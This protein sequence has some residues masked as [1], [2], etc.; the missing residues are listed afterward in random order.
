VDRA[1]SLTEVIRAAFVA[2]FFLIGAASPVPA[3]A[4]RVAIEISPSVARYEPALAA[5]I[6]TALPGEIQKAL[7]GRYTGPLRV[8]INDAKILRQPGFGI[9]GRDDYLDGVVIA[10]GREPIP[11]RLTLPFDRSMFSF[12]PQGEALRAR[13]LIE[14]FAQWVGKYI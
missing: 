8:R 13:N 2:L 6:R 7:A 12:T 3:Q 9:A 1:G 10:P 4:Q 11:I 5:L 14:V